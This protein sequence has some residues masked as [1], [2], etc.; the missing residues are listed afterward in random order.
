[1]KRFAKITAVVI[2]AIALIAAIVGCQKYDWGPIGSTDKEGDV[3][4]NGTLAVVQRDT[5]YFVNG[6]D[7]LSSIVEPKNNY[8]G[9][10]SKKGSVYKADLNSDGSISNVQ[11]LVPK[12]FYT[13]NSG[14][15]IYV[16][17]EWIYYTSPSTETDKSGSVLTSQQEFLRTK[18]DGTKTQQIALLSSNTYDYVF[19]PSGLFYYNSTDRKLV[20]VSY[21][22]SD[23]GKSRD[24]AEKVSGVN[25]VRDGSYQYGK[26]ELSDVIFYTVDVD[27]EDSSAVYGN[28]AYA[29]DYSG[30]VI[31]LIDKDTYG[32][33]G[34]AILQ[35]QYSIGLL[36]SVVESDGSVTLYYTK[37]GYEGSTSS[38][39]NVFTVAYKFGA[40]DLAFE[41]ADA[42]KASVNKDRERIIARSALSSI[43]PVSYDYGVLVVSESAFYRYYNDGV[44]CVK[45]PINPSDDDDGTGEA[46]S[47][48][49]TIIG[50]FDETAGVSNGNSAGKYVYYT[51]SNVL[52][53]LNLGGGYEIKLTDSAQDTIVGDFV[54]PSIVKRGSGDNEKWLLFYQNGVN[55]NY[56]Y[57]MD[58]K[59]FDLS[60]DVI[61]GLPVGGFYGVDE[62]KDDKNYAYDEASGN[63]KVT[64]PD[65]SNS[66]ISIK[67][68][69]PRTMTAT[70]LATYIRDNKV[71]DE[72]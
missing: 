37:T 47:G 8:F 28:T 50:I 70:D 67:T 64:D 61:Q 22:E 40:S 17:G 52:Y 6:K 32:V 11:L 15:G 13:G 36:A 3:T 25:F 29:C 58:I 26:S 42:T 24:I 68:A 10:A 30:R 20:T 57:Y 46:M 18:T 33:E 56:V 63:Y 19:T 60:G 7:D 65:D 55:S 51:I 1:M 14:G 54:K 45:A 48:A 49:P 41:G 66:V 9:N 44:D 72:D 31:K 2:L 59:S 53:K 16:Y 21:D 34:S 35:R 62:Y 5:L 43:T 23:V 71:T 39:Y 38:E 12:M 27:S 69:L 4:G